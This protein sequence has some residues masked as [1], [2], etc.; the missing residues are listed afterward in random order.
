MEI[1]NQ[2]RKS[3]P[4]LNEVETYL[5]DRP[6]DKKVSPLKWWRENKHRFPLI[7]IY[8]GSENTLL[9]QPHLPLQSVF[10]TGGLSVTK[11]RLCLVF[12]NKNAL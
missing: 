9:F 10:F 2:I 6:S 8:V 3:D 4:D 11:L 7:A 5:Q 1:L 12:L